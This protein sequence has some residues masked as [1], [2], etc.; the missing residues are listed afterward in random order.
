[1]ASQ[2]M[3]RPICHRQWVSLLY[4][5]SYSDVPTRCLFKPSI[6]GTLRRLNL[7]VMKRT[8]T[9]EHLVHVWCLLNQS[10]LSGYCDTLPLSQY[11]QPLLL[12]SAKHH[13]FLLMCKTS[14][15][16]QKKTQTKWRRN[17]L[18]MVFGVCQLT[19]G[20]IAWEIKQAGYVYI[21][22]C[23]SMYFRGLC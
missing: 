10:R 12:S 8:F 2:V 9:R 7:S 1:M 11:G 15:V 20:Y 21:P 18:P 17:F 5:L 13:F 22:F 16:Q 3:P 4:S 23:G 19:S 6:F 14:F